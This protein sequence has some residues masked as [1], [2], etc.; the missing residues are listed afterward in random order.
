MEFVFAL[1]LLAV[2]WLAG[3][4][5][6]LEEEE[7]GWQTFVITTIIGIVIVLLFY[8]GVFPTEAMLE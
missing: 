3:L 1:M 5:G 7:G 4:I 2:M 6:M 8:F